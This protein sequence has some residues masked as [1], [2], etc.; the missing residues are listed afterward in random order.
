MIAYHIG[1]IKSTEDCK[2]LQKDLDTLQEWERKWKMEFHPKKCQLIT[3]T[4][5]RKPIKSEYVIHNERLSE[6]KSAKYLR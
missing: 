4:K 3:I 6:T 5:K 2:A 1:E